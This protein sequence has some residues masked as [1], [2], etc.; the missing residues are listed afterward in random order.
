MSVVACLVAAGCSQIHPEPDL[1]GAG[2]LQSPT[3]EQD[4]LREDEQHEEGRR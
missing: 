3:H 2:E 1:E 4:A